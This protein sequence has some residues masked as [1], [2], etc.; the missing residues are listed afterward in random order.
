MF[1][2]RNFAFVTGQRLHGRAGGR[3]RGGGRRTIALRVVTRVRV[4]SAAI[5]TRVTPLTNSQTKFGFLL[6]RFQSYA[7]LINIKDS[8]LERYLKHV[9]SLSPADV[10]YFFFLSLYISL[11]LPLS[12]FVSSQLED[13]PKFLPVRE[14]VGRN[15]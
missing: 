10:I 14:L 3:G 1:H 2:A 13:S 15:Y 9:P 8:P 6:L 7:H 5:R 4:S 12:P 11:P